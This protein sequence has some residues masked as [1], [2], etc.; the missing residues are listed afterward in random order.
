MIEQKE[1]F[2]L[3]KAAVKLRPTCKHKLKIL[4]CVDDTTVDSYLM[5]CNICNEYFRT[6]GN[7]IK[8]R[9]YNLA[10]VSKANVVNILA[11]WDELISQGIIC[12]KPLQ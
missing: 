4:R 7:D 2:K 6:Y 3:D 12:V 9:K 5:Q 1:L 8:T 10:W 11:Q